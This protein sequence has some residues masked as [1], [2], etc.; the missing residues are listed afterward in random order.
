MKRRRR[1]LIGA[2]LALTAWGAVEFAWRMGTPSVPEAM[3]LWSEDERL[4]MA[5]SI[6]LGKAD[7]SRELGYT[8]A[9]RAEYFSKMRVWHRFQR[10]HQDALLALRGLGFPPEALLDLERRTKRRV[11]DEARKAVGPLPRLTTSQERRLRPLAVEWEGVWLMSDPIVADAVGLTEDQ[12]RAFVDASQG[13]YSR[14]SI[15]TEQMLYDSARLGGASEEALRPNAE[16]LEYEKDR[17]HFRGWALTKAEQDARQ[18][19]W[20]RLRRSRAPR[21]D[22]TFGYWLNNHLEDLRTRRVWAFRKDEEA[23]LFATLT[24]DQRARWNAFCAG[25]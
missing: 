22:G 8:P 20:E 2:G 17:W 6:L 23:R 18:E 21:Y 7:R 11:L 10:A 9:Q 13:V 19:R 12:R 24:P 25:R 14:F 15:E 4:G 1:L 5:Y 16:L 3:P